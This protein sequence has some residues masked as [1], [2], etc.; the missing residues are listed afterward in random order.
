MGGEVFFTNLQE[1]HA[2]F[3]VVGGDADKLGLP[4]LFVAGEEI[5]GGDGVAEHGLQC[6][7]RLEGCDN[8]KLKSICDQCAYVSDVSI[9]DAWICR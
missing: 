9:E 1:I 8:F 4:L 2:G 6:R 7:G 5:A 3:C